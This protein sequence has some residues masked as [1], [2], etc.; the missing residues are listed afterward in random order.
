MSIDPVTELFDYK[1][2]SAPPS[3]PIDEVEGGGG[4]GGEGTLNITVS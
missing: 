4:D 3:T 2:A 1:A